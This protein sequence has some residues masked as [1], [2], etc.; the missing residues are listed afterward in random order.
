LV[1]YHKLS[2]YKITFFIYKML[3]RG[4]GKYLV[5]HKMKLTVHK[6]ICDV[7]QKSMANNAFKFEAAGTLTHMS[8]ANC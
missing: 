8:L 6:R 7:L 2:K 5:S 4:V 1:L 3:C